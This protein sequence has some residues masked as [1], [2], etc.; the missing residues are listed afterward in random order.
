MING[1]LVTDKCWKRVGPSKTGTSLHLNIDR[2]TNNSCSEHNGSPHIPPLVLTWRGDEPLDRLHICLK[3]IVRPTSSSLYCIN[4]I[5]FRPQL[6][7][8]Q[9]GHQWREI[10]LELSM[11]R[12]TTILQFLPME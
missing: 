9:F 10:P 6:K 2:T 3:V 1:Y 11:V 7:R 12:T 8:K 5:Y 4:C